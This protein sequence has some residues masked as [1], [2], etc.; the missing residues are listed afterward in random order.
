[1]KVSRRTQLSLYLRNDVGILAALCRSLATELVNVDALCVFDTAETGVVRLVATDTALA[2]SVLE[3]SGYSVIESDVLFVE[4]PNRPGAA[5][6]IAVLSADAGLNIEYL[7]TSTH[8]SIDVATIV[9]RA[10]QIERLEL[11]LGETP[12]D[13]IAS[14][15]G[16]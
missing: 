9:V 13:E 8:P 16:R 3:A 15:R 14:T 5:A 10:R 4:V 7:Y 2:R 12:T 11:L 1:M 6:E